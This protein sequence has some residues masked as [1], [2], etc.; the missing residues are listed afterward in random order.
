M[1]NSYS[2]NGIGCFLIGMGILFVGFIIFF[3]TVIGPAIHE[4]GNQ[5]QACIDK[6]GIWVDSSR[7]CLKPDRLMP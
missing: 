4:K 5:H 7:A 2:N 1:V 6:G 3:A